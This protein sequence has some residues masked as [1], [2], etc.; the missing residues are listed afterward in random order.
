[1]LYPKADPQRRIMVH[2][3]R[4]CPYDEI[5]EN[6]CVY[7][8]DLLTVTKYASQSF[9][10]FPLSIRFL[11]PG[12]R[13]ESR[14]TLAR[15]RLW[16]VPFVSKTANRIPRLFIAVGSLKHDMSELR[17]CRVFIYPSEPRWRKL[18]IRLE[19]IVASS[20]RTSRNGS[21]HA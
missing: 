12:N 4:I 1:L 5:A 8:N 18:L 9:P 3:C 16:Y 13:R 6:K 19:F 10:F 21:R 15:T 2:A 7:R 14:L 11:P 17:K 20:S